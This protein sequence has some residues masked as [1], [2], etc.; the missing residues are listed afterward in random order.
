MILTITKAGHIGPEFIVWAHL[1]EAEDPSI[2]SES[3]IIGSG[4][5]QRDAIE[6]GIQTLS[7]GMET[8][9]QMLLEPQR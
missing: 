9:N 1:L 8:L 5:T 7:T 3:F 4:P 2:A 6:Q